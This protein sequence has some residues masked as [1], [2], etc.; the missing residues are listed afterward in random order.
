MTGIVVLGRV[1]RLLLLVG[2]VFV[3]LPAGSALADTTI[4]QAVGIAG[5]TCEGGGVD[6]DATY[7]VPAGGGT[8]TS[9][10]F[11]STA[12]NV[13]E[14]LDFLV[15]QHVSGTTYQVVGKTGLKTLAGTG[16]VETFSTSISVQ[17]G[18]IIGLWFPGTLHTCERFAIGEGGGLLD[19]ASATDPAIARASISLARRQTST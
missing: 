10:S 1:R 5:S 6:A 7:V 8:I 12:A 18:Q 15:L 9:F 14:Q 19:G 17:A 13:G 11:Q 16:A 3:A 2:F 4:G